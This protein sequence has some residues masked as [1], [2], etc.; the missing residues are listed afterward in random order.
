Y[1]L[2]IGRDRLIDPARGTIQIPVYLG[3]SL[4]WQ[5]QSLDLWSAGHLTIRADD[6]RELFDSELRFPDALLDDA[7]RFD[8][9]VTE[10]ANRAAK[11]R[12]GAAVPSL[13]AVFQR[14]AVPQQHR[15]VIEGTFRTMCRLHD[16]GRDHIWG[17]YVRNLA[18]PIWLAREANRVDVLIGNPPW[19]AYRHMTREMQTAF[20]RMSEVRGIWAGAEQATHQDLAGLF[21][22]RACQLYLRN[23]GQFALVMPNT[24]IDRDHYRGF[25]TGR[26]G[27]ATLGMQI[28]FTAPW[29]LRRIRPHFFPR[30]ASVV[31]GARTGARAVPMPEDAEIWTGRLPATNASWGRASSAIIRSVGRLRRSGAL[32]RSPYAPAFTQGAVVLPRVAFVV[33]RQ[34]A[35]A[36]GLPSGR[37]SVASSRS[38]QEKAPWKKVEGLA[39]VIESEFVRPI[40]TGDALFPYRCFSEMEAVLPCSSRSLLTKDQVELH[41]GLHQW[42]DRAEEVWNAHRSNDRMTLM[43][44]LDYQSKLTKQLPIPEL[45]V[46]Y[47][48]SGMHVVASKL[49]DRRGVVASGLYWCSVRSEIEADYICAILNAPITTELARPFMSYGKDERDIAKHIWELP[50]PSFDDG[51]PTHLR[52]AQLGAGAEQLVAAFPINPDLH[53]A[54]TRRHIR[55]LIET[56]SEG[57]EIDEIVYELIS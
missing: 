39:G 10:L 52:L 46:V 45:R 32:T 24:A 44:Q 40:Y 1:L 33:Q 17:Y 15:A 25:R 48:R 16:E 57:R 35:S 38:V 55:Q 30:A 27:D 50:I 23:G 51:N 19:L 6:D 5:E 49:R 11:R 29:D 12:P 31:F 4:Q 54:A 2:A 56:T 21:A 28:A 9:L 8:E 20:K 14:L 42:W 37:V 13:S 26:Y 41:P 18:R 36:L 3:D 22:V 7:A 43:Q 53:F 47:N 34:A